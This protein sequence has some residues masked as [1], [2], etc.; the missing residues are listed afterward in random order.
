M[1]PQN[2]IPLT[3]HGKPLAGVVHDRQTNTQHESLAGSP[4]RRA[5]APYLSPSTH[6]LATRYGS[7]GNRQSPANNCI[8]SFEPPT[9][10]CEEVDYISEPPQYM[11]TVRS[12][13]IAQ[14]VQAWDSSWEQMENHMSS[15]GSSGNYN[16]GINS[17]K[18]SDSSSRSSSIRDSNSG[19]GNSERD[20]NP[21]FD[22]SGN[23]SSMGSGW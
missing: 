19:S 18:S 1:S 23:A 22:A 2:S 8:Q 21:D 12:L 17:D 9:A 11:V 4:T 15:S 20:R 7:Q 3:P 16:C 5:T 13:S 6:S 14:Y 10:G